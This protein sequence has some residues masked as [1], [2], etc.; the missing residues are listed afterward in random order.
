MIHLWLTT[1]W[2]IWL[3]LKIYK[4]LAQLNRG[5]C[6]MHVYCSHMGAWQ[7]SPGGLTAA[8]VVT[9]LWRQAACWAHKCSGNLAYVFMPLSLFL[10][11][12]KLV[13]FSSTEIEVKTIQQTTGWRSSTIFGNPTVWRSCLMAYKLSIYL[14]WLVEILIPWHD[15]YSHRAKGIHKNVAELLFGLN[16]CSYECYLTAKSQIVVYPYAC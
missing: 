4:C 9:K 16:K 2:L 8:P 13:L 3:I 5:T 6:S 15:Y 1:S 10:V 11:L 14:A 12:L 7:N